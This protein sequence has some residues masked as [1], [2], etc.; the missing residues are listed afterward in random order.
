MKWS[1]KNTLSFLGLLVLLVSCTVQKRRY[2]SGYQMSWHHSLKNTKQTETQHA[3]KT[4]A[5]TKTSFSEELTKPREAKEQLY[6]SASKDKFAEFNLT[7]SKIRATPP[8]SCGDVLILKTGEEQNEKI[9]EVVNRM[10]KYKR[11]SNLGGPLYSINKDLLFLIKHADGTKEVVQEEVYT[12]N[13]VPVDNSPVIKKTNGWAIASFVCACTFFLII[14]W[15]LAPIFGC[16]AAYKIDSS[17]KKYKGRWMALV[18]IA[19]GF[20]GLLILTAL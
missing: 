18:G 13:G 16:I 7:A 20:I 5:P 12:I 14:P 10:I 15:I 11:C 17:P 1:L 9:V 2:R 19:I 4:E 6:A 8:D 3:A